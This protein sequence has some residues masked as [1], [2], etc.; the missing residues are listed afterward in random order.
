MMVMCSAAVIHSVRVCVCVG[1]ESKHSCSDVR[2]LFTESS[3]T[4]FPAEVSSK[5]SV[6]VGSSAAL[7]PSCLNFSKNAH[8]VFWCQEAL[9]KATGL[10]TE[11]V[12]TGPTLCVCVCVRV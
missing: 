9:S 11:S 10:A 4:G 5:S 12:R 1:G 8:Y 3:V 7:E 2:S 6:G